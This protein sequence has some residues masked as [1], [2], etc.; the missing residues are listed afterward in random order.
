MCTDSD[1]ENM[2]DE[3]MLSD[4]NDKT[5]P[6]DDVPNSPMSYNDETNDVAV[7]PQFGEYFYYITMY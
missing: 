1:K 3:S 5:T 4:S 6:A 7:I 2:E